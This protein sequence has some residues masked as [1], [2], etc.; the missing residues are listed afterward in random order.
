MKSQPGDSTTAT[1]LKMTPLIFSLLLLQ[2]KAS[3]ERQSSERPHQQEP[4]RKVRVTM[5]SVHC[6][7]ALP[8]VSDGKFQ[9]RLG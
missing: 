9:V 6:C 3:I 2:E 7:T 4:L 1:K 8:R 5:D